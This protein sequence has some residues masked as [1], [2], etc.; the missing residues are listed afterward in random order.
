MDFMKFQRFLFFGFIWFYLAG[1]HFFVYNFKDFYFLVYLGDSIG[2]G[3]KAT[4]VP[5]KEDINN[6]NKK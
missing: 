5:Q 4:H 2:R 1:L 6:S 3:I